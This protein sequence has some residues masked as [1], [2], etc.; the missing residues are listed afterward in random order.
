MDTK[1]EKILEELIGHGKVKKYR[2]GQVYIPVDA[3]KKVSVDGD[4]HEEAEY[5]ADMQ[6]V[7][8]FKPGIDPEIL[9]LSIDLISMYL[10]KQIELNKKTREKREKDRH[11]GEEIG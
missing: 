4:T 11:P 3:W 8:L 7:L 1:E 5:V 9:R 10:E 2:T 6:T